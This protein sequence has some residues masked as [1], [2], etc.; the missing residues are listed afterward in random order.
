M[1]H[2][3]L[4]PK[5]AGIYKLTCKINGKIY[6]GKAINLY[7]RIIQHKCRAKKPKGTWFFENAI[8]K[9][10]WDSF[11][12]DILEIMEPF[13]KSKDNSILLDKESYY[14][15][16]YDSTNKEK[17]YNIQ[18]HVG[19]DGTGNPKK[20]ITEEHR[21]NL[22]K[23]RALQVRGPL[24]EEQIE[25]MRG[26]V[27]T[28]ETREKIRNTKKGI[29]LSEEHKRKIGESGIGRKHSPEA[30]EKI[31]QSKLGKH[32]TDEAKIKMSKA[33]LG[34]VGTRLGTLQS[35]ETRKK[36]SESKVGKP[37]PRLGVVLSDEIKEKMR[38]AKLKKTK[39][40]T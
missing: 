25:K 30:I 8:I 33:K 35:E 27:C 26:R 18:K 32:H 4:I 10:G 20:P 24:T 14:I 9:H 17:G 11:T 23:A 19:E 28:E 31:R 21:E 15:E 13:D 29:K 7:N 6:I 34:K 40:I 39:R 22:R 3:S 1:D 12:I 5:K 2:V 36:I 16:K 38:Q 37:S